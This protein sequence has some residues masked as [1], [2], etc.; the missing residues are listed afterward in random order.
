VDRGHFSLIADSSLA[1]LPLVK[2]R[3]SI[4]SFARC[5]GRRRPRA[6]AVRVVRLSSSNSEGDAPIVAALREGDDRAFHELFRR[7]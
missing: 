6:F 4:C 3:L 5:A 2:N 1:K 7:K